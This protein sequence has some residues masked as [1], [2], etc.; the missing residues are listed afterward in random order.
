[1]M[2][3]FAALIALVVTIA[4]FGA[5]LIHIRSVRIAGSRSG[6]TFDT[7]RAG[8]SGGHIPA[9]VLSH[10]Y[11]YFQDWAGVSGFP[12]RPQDPISEVYGI[13]EEDLDAQ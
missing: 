7:F 9:H 5:V 11:S 10:V 12:V 3:E 6:E 1:M 13:V 2:L 4:A 8:F